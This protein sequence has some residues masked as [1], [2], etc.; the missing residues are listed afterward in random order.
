MTRN[1]QSGAMT[2]VYNRTPDGEL[3]CAFSAPW[4]DHWGPGCARCEAHTRD[5]LERHKKRTAREKRHKL[6]DRSRKN[7]RGSLA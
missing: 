4:L 5:A 1:A 7:D 6:S 2:K 3:A